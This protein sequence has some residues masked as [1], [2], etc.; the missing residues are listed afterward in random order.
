ML[1]KETLGTI[2]IK[3]DAIAKFRQEAKE[4]KTSIV[5]FMSKL[6]DSF[7]T[8]NASE[9]QSTTPVPSLLPELEGEVIM[10]ATPIE[11]EFVCEATPID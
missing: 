9:N 5:K 6:A 10:Q 8:T 1:Y 4:K 11:D 3:K 7:P 2:R